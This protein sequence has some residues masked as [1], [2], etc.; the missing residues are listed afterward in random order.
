MTPPP[1]TRL[2][3]CRYYDRMFESE[4]MTTY[5][6]GAVQA[7]DYSRVH[8]EHWAAMG[9]PHVHYVRVCRMPE[10]RACT[11]LPCIGSLPL[12]C[13]A[14]FG[15]SVLPCCLQ[16]DNPTTQWLHRGCIGL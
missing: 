14:R 10:R 12:C 1:T 8:M 4:A 13:D 2:G 6:A 7:W 11:R 9:L 15:D 3:P 5:M 16:G